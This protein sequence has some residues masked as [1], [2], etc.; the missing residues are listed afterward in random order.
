MNFGILS[1]DFRRYSLETCFQT[2]A[3]L[4][5]SG[6]E[7]WGGRPHAFPPDMD[8]TCTKQILSLKK[9]YGL[10]MP[11]Y[12]PN[13]IGMPINLCS[14][15]HRERCE[16]LAYFKKSIEVASAL[17][18]P[19]MLLVADH[20]GYE[21]D[22]VEAEKWFAQAVAILADYGQTYGV[23]IAVEPLTRLESP[24][25]CTSDDCYKLLSQVGQE[26][27]DFVLDVVPAAVASEPVSSYF[28]RL[29][30]QRVRHVH[31]CNSDGRTDAHLQLDDGILSTPDILHVLHDCQYDGFVI[32]ELYSVSSADPICTLTK[33]AR[34]LQKYG[35]M[36]R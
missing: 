30:L 10:E 24:V 28:S 13:C 6:V 31:L 14:P 33:T 18:I 9:Q 7:L 34:L 5:F 22:I 36:K 20:P 1:L 17:E 19:R 4:G 15:M 12:T 23:R 2:A 8:N 25:V 27:I 3:R 29:T 16:G 35:E 26:K 11:M 32:T 21:T